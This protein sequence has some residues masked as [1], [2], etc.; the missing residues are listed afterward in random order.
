MSIWGKILGSAAGFALGGP[1]GAVAGVVAGHAVDLYRASPGDAAAGGAADDPRA[2]TR[3]I[4]FTIATI[5]LGAKLAKADGVVSRHEV[6]A[7]KEAFHVPAGEM[8]N[9]ARLYDRAKREATGYEPYARQIAELLRDHP[10]VL[11]ELLDALF[12]IAHADGALHEAEIE[13]L[14][15]VAAIFGFSEEEFRRIRAANGAADEDDPHIVLGVDSASSDAELKAAYRRLVL[16]HH[17]DRLVARGLPRE[18][19][20]VATDKMATINEAYRRIRE[21]RGFA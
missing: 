12:H 20:A 16:E 8:G 3:Q 6:S 18:F 14:R 5:V 19:I 13:Y 15:K 7:F 21:S 17:P 11:E 2:P 1:L 10:P 9:V 4:A